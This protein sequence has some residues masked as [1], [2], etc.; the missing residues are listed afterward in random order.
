MKPFS[1]E[2]IICLKRRMEMLKVFM[3]LLKYT[4]L[5]G[6]Q[7]VTK[8][9]FLRMDVDGLGQ[10]FI[11]GLDE[12]NKIICCICHPINDARCIF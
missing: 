12:S 2:V 3:T 6:E 5:G 1:M 8:L 10:I 11:K 9:G 4:D 7:K